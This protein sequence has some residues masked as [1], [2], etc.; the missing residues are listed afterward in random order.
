MEKKK[1][2]WMIVLSLLGAVLFSQYHRFSRSFFS[3]F[4]GEQERPLRESPGSRGKLS[5]PLPILLI[6]P[7]LKL[8]QLKYVQQL[9]GHVLTDMPQGTRV[10]ITHLSSFMEHGRGRSFLK[11]L[12]LVETSF[13][14]GNQY[15]F[16]ASYDFHS[17]R[18]TRTWAGHHDRRSGSGFLFR[19]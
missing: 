16:R 5:S 3:M 14:D 12:I 4:K 10:V 6:R 17:K 15:A 18:I 8:E 1:K 9:K 2:Q 19:K 13:P 11:D 7:N